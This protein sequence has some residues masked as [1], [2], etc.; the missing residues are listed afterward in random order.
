MVRE[1]VYL[2]QKTRTPGQLALWR[3]TFWVTNQN[4]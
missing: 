3:I 2:G 4:P 1:T